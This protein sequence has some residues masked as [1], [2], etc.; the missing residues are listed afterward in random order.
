MSFCNEM[1]Y[2]EPDQKHMCGEGFKKELDDKWPAGSMHA[3]CVRFIDGAYTKWHYHTGEQMLFATEGEG[4]VEF[5]HGSTLEVSEGT[6][7]YIPVGVWHRH[8]AIEGKALAHLAV[9]CGDTKWNEED[10][11]QKD[12]KYGN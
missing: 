5:Q 11:C 10:P 8:G 9:T 3:T 7:V 2:G 4:F 1:T 6:H 12:P